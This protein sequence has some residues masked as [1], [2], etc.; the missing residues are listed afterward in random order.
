LQWLQDPSERN[1]DNLKI[2]ATRHF[3]N[4]KREYLKDRINEFERG[5]QLRSNLVNSEND[6]LLQFP[7]F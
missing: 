3:R 6:N 1:G 2:E 7:Q 5:C 4:N